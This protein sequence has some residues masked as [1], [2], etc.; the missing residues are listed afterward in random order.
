MKLF[1]FAAAAAVVAL[2]PLLPSAAQA[3]RY[4]QADPAGDVVTVHYNPLSTVPAPTV[5]EGDIVSSSVRHKARKVLLTMRFVELDRTGQG[6][7]FFY[8]IRTGSMTRYV[9]LAAA[10]GRWAGKAQVVKPSGKK[11]SCRVTRAIDYAANTATIGVPRSCLG[12]P[13]W[14]KVGMQAASYIDDLVYG[15]DARTNGRIYKYMVFTPKVR[16]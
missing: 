10:P 8:G 12:D 16:R 1:R 15:D 6:R 11:V 13:R 4:V 5:T 14:V 7:I 3:D 9:T 2:V